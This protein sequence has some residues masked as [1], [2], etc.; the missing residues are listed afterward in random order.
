M[1][2]EL[3]SLDAFGSSFVLSQKC[4]SGLWFLAEYSPQLFS[5]RKKN[6]SSIF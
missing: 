2:L 3:L 4:Y 6:G 1:V 5:S